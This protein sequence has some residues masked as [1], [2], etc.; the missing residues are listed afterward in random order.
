M[1]KLP[2]WPLYL[3]AAPAAVAIWGGWVGLGTM[4]GF[5]PV[6]LLPGIVPS[7]QVNLAITLPVGVEAY[8]SYALGTW[9]DPRTPERAREYARTSAISSLVVGCLG[10]VVYH[11]LAARH[12][13]AAP[14]PVVLL[15]S[16]VPV[17]T[18]GL[19]A[20][21]A[22]LTRVPARPVSVPWPRPAPVLEPVLVAAVPEPAPAPVA[23]PAAAA[24]E[25]APDKPAPVRPATR[26]KPAPARRR[27]PG[28]PPTVDG[29][30]PEEL[31][32][33]AA[34]LS[35]RALASELDITEWQ[36]QQIKK[37]YPKPITAVNGSH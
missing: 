33:L 14:W 6:H 9:L 5:G 4:C 10:Q 2:R 17:I 34:K 35:K 25:P 8:G 20:T 23:Q 16:C 12:V 37:Y 1:R 11:L 3:I 15:V 30:T 28:Q 24:P 21:L 32:E 29:K 22:H 18:L 26:P 36:A 7:F 19:G 13:T 31:R 27:A